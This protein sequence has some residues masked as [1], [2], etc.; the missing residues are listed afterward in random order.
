MHT[1]DLDISIVD[2]DKGG[3]DLANEFF[4]GRND[5]DIVLEPKEE[6]N[7][8]SGNKI[9]KIR[10]LIKMQGKEPTKNETGED[11]DP[12]EGGDGSVMNLSGVGHV[13]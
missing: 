13:E 2:D 10:V 4:D 5:E 7:E 8:S 6:D 11:A 9:L 3:Q 12:A 1:T